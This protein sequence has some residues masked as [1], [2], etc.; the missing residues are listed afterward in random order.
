MMRKAL[1][2]FWETYISAPQTYD[3]GYAC[4]KASAKLARD[5]ELVG[6][7][8]QGD[9]PFERTPFDD[10]WRDALA[11]AMRDRHVDNP[12]EYLAEPRIAP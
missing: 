4:G 9:S 2:H 6:M 7:W 10:G 3:R 12:V 11:E 8:T 5:V 1:K